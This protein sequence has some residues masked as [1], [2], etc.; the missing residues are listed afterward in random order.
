MTRRGNIGMEDTRRTGQ[1]RNS[2]GRGRAASQS[3]VAAAL[4]P[5]ESL[6]IMQPNHTRLSSL[7]SDPFTGF[8][9]RFQGPGLHQGF[10]AQG[11]ASPNARAV[12]TNQGYDLNPV[13]NVRTTA[14][15]LSSPTGA[16][17][18]PAG[19]RRPRVELPQEQY[20][21][22][23]LVPTFYSMAQGGLGSLAAKFESGDEGVAAIGYD[24][25]G[26][27]SYGKYQIASLTGTMD[28]FITYLH[29]HAPDLAKRLSA[30]GPA[31]TGGRN[32]NMPAVWREISSENPMRFERLQSEFIRTS[33]FEPAI[34]GIALTTGL[35][36][37]ALPKALQ[38][39]LFSTA[40]QHG[41]E[42]AVRIVT[43]A[44]N[45]LGK[46]HQQKLGKG[47]MGTEGNQAGR[48]LIQSI[49]NLRAGQFV[50]STAR[51]RRAVKQRLHM[52]MQEALQM[53][54]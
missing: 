16:G 15:L 24:R 46:K 50:S 37:D 23:S 20:S 36:F 5:P 11:F 54:S 34:Q 43:R 2:H 13:Q 19:S 47:G 30:A 27:T 18:A 28:K 38:E 42:G 39:V 22:P 25:K 53:L 52:E 12:L 10:V 9:A 4:G 41:P 29:D 14:R 17:S 26:G 40:V 45:S 21:A 32:G 51:V 8:A 49:Y 44:V 7:G 31:N 35:S 33:H 48:Q 3:E 6:G 1:A